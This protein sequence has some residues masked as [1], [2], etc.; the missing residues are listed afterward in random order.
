VA[1]YFEPPEDYK[2][3][4]LLI[5][6]LRERL[7]GGNLLPNVRQEPPLDPYARIEAVVLVH[8][9]NNHYGE[10][11]KS[12]HHFRLRQ[13]ERAVPQLPPPGL[14]AILA[15]LFWP[16][17]AAWW[18]FLDL[19][20]FLV[21]PK[22]V[23]TARDAAPLLARH[24]RS[25]PNLRTVH[26]V[27]HSLGCRI[28]LKTID[29][30]LRYGGPTVGKVCLMAAAVPLF[31]VQSG[32]EL[33]DAM[34]HA[35]HVGEVR[36]L[37]SDD[38]WVLR[39]TFPPGQT[40]ARGNDEGFFP[41][42][43]GLHGPLGVAART[44]PFDI[45]DARHGDYWGDSEQPPASLAADRIAEFFHFGSWQRTIASRGAGMAPRPSTA[46]SREV[47]YAREI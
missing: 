36:I 15:D 6:Q 10:A 17:D 43:L 37:Y 35:G 18:G 40:L 4:E 26:F 9:F 44:D 30:I 22:A 13:Y 8:G 21:Y 38:D 23:G 46:D 25:M 2:P 11:G 16:G 19:F 14:E 12:Y 31:K 33:A 47:G 45:T 28:I 32:G 34:E 42:A 1:R 41:T 7:E 24:L 29:D 27:G 20:D 3:A 39:D 5:F